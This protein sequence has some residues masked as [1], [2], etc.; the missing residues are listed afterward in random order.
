MNCT[1]VVLLIVVVYLYHYIVPF[2]YCAF[3]YWSF[4]CPLEGSSDNM[5]P[6]NIQGREAWDSRKREGDDGSEHNLEVCW[7]E[8]ED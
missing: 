6:H 8:R 2:I 1:I 3:Y 4:I 7:E 5:W